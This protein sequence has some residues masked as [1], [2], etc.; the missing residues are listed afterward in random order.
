MVTSK[1]DH[2]TDLAAAG[3]TGASGTTRA[4][5]ATTS[6]TARATAARR[7]LVPGPAPDLAT[8]IFTGTSSIL[9]A[10]APRAHGCSLPPAAGR[11]PSPLQ[12]GHYRTDG[13]LSAHEC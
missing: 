5:T 1:R 13:V 6:A 11:N 8:R 10:N 7:P 9:D 4:S 3:R 12:L 2:W